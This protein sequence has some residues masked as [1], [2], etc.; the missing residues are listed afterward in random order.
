MREKIQHIMNP[1]MLLSPGSQAYEREKT[2]RDLLAMGVSPAPAPAASMPSSSTTPAPL[3]RSSTQTIGSKQGSVFSS[4]PALPTRPED[5]PLEDEP[6]WRLYVGC[7]WPLHVWKRVWKE[8]QNLQLQMQERVNDGLARLR[9][10]KKW[11][12]DAKYFVARRSA[13]RTVRKS[14]RKIT[15]QKYWK[16]LSAHVKHQRKCN[17]VTSSNEY[18]KLRTKRIASLPFFALRVYSRCKALVRSRSFGELMA[19]KEALVEPMAVPPEWRQDE[20]VGPLIKKAEKRDVQ[21]RAAN[22]HCRKR[23]APLLFDL[24]IVNV[25]LARRKRYCLLRGY[26]IIYARVFAL[27]HIY[28]VM[29]MGIEEEQAKRELTGEAEVDA[30][31]ALGRRKEEP[32]GGQGQGFHSG[33]T[34]A[35]MRKGIIMADGGEGEGSA[36]EAPPPPP[37]PP[38]IAEAPSCTFLAPGIAPAHATSAPSPYANSAPS[39]SS[40]ANAIAA[41]VNAGLDGLAPSAAVFGGDGF[42]RTEGFTAKQAKEAARERMAAKRQANSKNRRTPLPK[43]KDETEKEEEEGTVKVAERGSEVITFGEILQGRQG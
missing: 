11:R 22:R 38:Q 15:I 40:A 27:W 41:G 19:R 26:K 17:E 24:L 31:A 18:I 10:F 43:A 35:A 5:E 16:R 20:T 7:F 29:G 13:S 34:S 42:E 2:R 30:V 37:P 8:S 33:A 36:A 32:Q 1:D 14:N 23:L 6:Q 21:R 25:E 9:S 4:V 3:K 12:S 39:A 28:V